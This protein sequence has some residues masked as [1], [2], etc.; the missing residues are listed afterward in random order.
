MEVTDK[1]E[2]LE[3]LC[4][5]YKSPSITEENPYYEKCMFRC[6]GYDKRCPY[7]APIKYIKE[8]KAREVK[9]E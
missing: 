5:W 2:T 3:D 4:I 1:Q 7:Y 8:E 9:N 6:D